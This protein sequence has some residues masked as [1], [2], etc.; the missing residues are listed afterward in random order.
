MAM[1]L[2]EHAR[3][4]EVPPPL[5]VFACDLD[6]QAIA[7]AR[8]GIYPEVI[9]ADV[10]E[11]RL[12]KFFVKEH[13]GYRVRRELREMVLFAAHDLLKDPP[14]SRIDLICCR[15]LLIYL[16]R[17]AQM[18][19]FETFHFALRPAGLLLL[20]TSEAIED[21]SALFRTV[22][23]KNR[24]YEQRPAL[25]LGLPV[26]SGPNSLLRVIAAHEQHAAE[27]VVHGRRFLADPAVGF[28]G[29]LVP[30]LDRV[31]L[32]ELHFKLIERFAPPSILVNAE[33]DIVHLSE[34]S[35]KLL[36]FVG[37]EPTANLVRVVHPMIRIELRAALFRA[38]ESGSAVR[39]EA[40]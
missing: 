8:A 28:Q 13:Q 40:G 17:D 23:K 30:A 32:S 9:S 5:Q 12:Q 11:E 19:V 38:A 24:M 22:D 3:T 4:L 6:E 33:H 36:H 31:S 29:Q 7:L 35:G 16:N 15:N 1:L 21:G 25:R 10:S 14:F 18:R 20:G 26:P 37:G 39:A 27:P 34:N 2:L